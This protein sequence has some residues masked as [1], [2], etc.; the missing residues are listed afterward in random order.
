MEPK[1]NPPQDSVSENSIDRTSNNLT[2]PEVDNKETVADG[3]DFPPVITYSTSHVGPL[4]DPETLRRYD[5]LVP[6]FA[7]ELA[8]LLIKE[9]EHRRLMETRELN[10]RGE[11]IDQEGWLI[12]ANSNRSM[13]GLAAG[14]VI[15]MSALGA[16]IYV[17]VRGYPWVGGVIGGATVTTLAGVFVIGKFQ[18]KQQ[19]KEIEESKKDEK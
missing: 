4:P 18:E 17:T 19:E 9:S 7:R 1:E 11:I 14:F 15:A 13:W 5:E 3:Q 12:K 2:P 16:S 10:I 6:G 8:S